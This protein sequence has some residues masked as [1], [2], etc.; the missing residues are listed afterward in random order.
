MSN[1]YDFEGWVTKYNR[2]CTDGRTL[3]YPAFKECDGK[4]VPMVWN[5][6]HDDPSKVMGN[7]VL[8]HRDE[9][10]WGYASFN[11]SEAGKQGKILVDHGDVVAMSIYAN[12]LKENASGYVQ[13][14]EIKEV[15]LVLAGANPDATIRNILRHGEWLDDETIIY[16]GETDEGIIL[17]GELF[18]DSENEN[19]E[20]T[21]SDTLKHAEENDNLT[22]EDVINTMNEQQKK[23]L[24]AL[25]AMAQEDAGKSVQHSDEGDNVMQYN[26]FAPDNNATQLDEMVLSHSEQRA[27]IDDVKRTGSL[28]SSFEAYMKESGRD[29]VLAHADDYGVKDT[30]LLFPEAHALNNGAPEFINLPDAWVEKVMSGVKKLPWAKV[31]SMW[32]DITEDEARAKGYIKGKYKKEEVFSLLKRQTNPT[33]VYKKQKMDRDDI[34]DI[35]FDVVTWMKG[36]MKVKLKEEL[37]RAYLL[38]DGRP[39]SSDDHIND[40]CIRPVVEDADLFVIRYGVATEGVTTS[41]AASNIIDCAV[42]AR[43]NY[44]G[45]GATTFFTTEDYLTDMLLLKDGIGHRLYKNES[46]LATAMRV[47]DIA[48]VPYLNGYTDKAG[49]KVVGVIVNMNDYSVG[50]DKGG[51]M[52]LFDDFDLNYNQ[53]LWLMETRCSGALT[54]P[55]SAIVLYA[56]E[57]NEDL[58]PSIHEAM[59]E[60]K[61]H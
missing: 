56:G 29:D 55:F 15:S 34:V 45:S 30:D 51:E 32:A 16:T 27:I 61:R 10:V 23:V 11:E 42:K 20:N 25:I 7:V 44:R 50:T 9:G 46:E 17:H 18:S 58:S 19:E 52:N 21:M 31:K 24:Y 59:D 8:E 12:R 54:K 49:R 6:R 36:E 26:V 22:V 5:H 33:T 1:N 40:Q 48:T 43:M 38:G 37:A 47:K 4:K 53:Q 13:H 57:D 3:M 35:D 2:R 28:K 14:G 41:E 60:F 39:A